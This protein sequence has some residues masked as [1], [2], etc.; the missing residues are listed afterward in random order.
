MNFPWDKQIDKKSLLETLNQISKLIKAYEKYKFGW[1]YL[2]PQNVHGKILD[3]ARG[4]KS[5]EEAWVYYKD[6][7]SIYQ[8]LKLLNNK[9]VANNPAL[10][11]KAYGQLLKG[12]GTVVGG[13]PFPAKV[14][15]EP[16]KVLG[17]KF[18]ATVK[19]LMPS[20]HGSGLD[21]DLRDFLG[22]GQKFINGI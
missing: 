3:A 18:E 21:A 12:V 7:E 16:L 11:A 13:L 19:V 14:Y 9:E 22:G 10:A 5:L 15:G 17:G 6:M 20:A 2:M 4:I 8:A 1:E